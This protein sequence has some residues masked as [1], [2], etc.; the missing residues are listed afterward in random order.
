MA[1]PDYLFGGESLLFNNLKTASNYND[2]RLQLYNN[3]SKDD[4][5]STGINAP[6]YDFSEAHN[7]NGMEVVAFEQIKEAI[8]GSALD[9]MSENDQTKSVTERSE[10]HVAMRENGGSWTDATVSTNYGNIGA[11]TPA[12]AVQQDGKAAVVWQQGV[13]KFNEQGSP[14]CPP[15]TS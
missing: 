6:M 2:D 10:I 12:V 14:A 5:V 3:G 1:R 4:L 7:D 8:D 13:A 15:T 9:A 11:V